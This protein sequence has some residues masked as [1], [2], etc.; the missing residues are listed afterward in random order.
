[1]DFLKE[2]VDTKTLD[3]VMIY[4]DE[5]I[6]FNISCNQDNVEKIIKFFIQL[7]ITVIDKLLIQRLDIFLLPYSKIEA[8]FAKY[9][10]PT[11]VSIINQDIA[12]IDIF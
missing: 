9:N 1:M 4:N 2:Y 12:N 10:I 8:T 5:S 3:K 7:G 11:L 6:I